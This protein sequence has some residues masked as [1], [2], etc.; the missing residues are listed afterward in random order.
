VNPNSRRERITK[1]L[2]K[3]V[4]PVAGS[5]LAEQLAV[6]RQVIVQDISI[7]RAMGEQILATPRGYIFVES[8]TPAV[9][10]KT[11]AMRHNHEEMKHE[12]EIIVDTGG[13]VVDVLVE[14]PVYGELKGML[15]LGSRR[16]IKEFIESLESSSSKPL[17]ALTDG[18]HLHTV[19]AAS[20]EVFF[21]IEK[22]L[23]RSGYLLK[24]ND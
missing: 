2:E 7:L 8:L 24:I 5:R 13:K 20:E 4:Q 23:E 17:S 22:E 14:H 9:Y 6:S 21:H 16:D 18:V 15:M 12:L 3:A 11:F 10:R 19:E 1:I